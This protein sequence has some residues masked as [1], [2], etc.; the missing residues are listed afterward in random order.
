VI[1]IAEIAPNAVLMALWVEERDGVPTLIARR[2]VTPNAFTGVDDL[3]AGLSPRFRVL[4]NPT[5]GPALLEIGPGVAGPATVAILDVSGRSVRDL[6]RYEMG[7][8][9]RSLVWDGRDNTGRPMGTGIYFAV[10]RRAGSET[11]R[12]F[13]VLR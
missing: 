3:A 6:G 4:P 11:H 2:G 9:G 7:T 1:G 12:S 13:V 5:H 8:E 10:V